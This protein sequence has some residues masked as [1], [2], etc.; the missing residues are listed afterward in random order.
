MQPDKRFLIGGSFTT[1]NGVSRNRVARI[2][3]DGSLDSSFNPGTGSN[4]TVLDVALQ[5][6]NKILI[7]GAFTSYNGTSRNRLARLNTDGSLDSTFNVGTGTDS[8]IN[9][10]A[11]QQN[12]KIL[13]GGFFANY[14]GA[15]ANRLA[16]INP[17]GSLDNT[18]VSGFTNNPIYNVREILVQTNGRVLIGGVFDS[19]SGTA[20]NSLLQLVPDVIKS[21]LFDFDGDGKADVSVFRPSNSVWYLLN[22]QTGFSAVQFGISTDKIAPADYDADGKTDVAVFRDGNWYLLRSSL[23]FTSVQFGSVGDIPAP[24][25]FN[26]DGRAELAVF[27]P[28]NGFWYVLNLVN[29]QFS[30]VQF[31]TAEDKPVAADYDGDGKS[32]YGVYRPSSGIWYLLQSTKGFGAIQFGIATD[33]PVVGDYDGD[34]RADQAVYRAESGIWYLLK[35]TQGFA[36]VQFGLSTDLPAAADY[37]GDGKTDVAVFRPNGGNWYQLKSAQGFGAVQFGSIGDKPAPNAFVP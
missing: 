8:A 18:F 15:S 9:T 33:K 13:I 7:A 25:D 6:D 17:D 35:T 14:N 23:G 37:D 3:A 5:P 24:A 12:G 32:D 22:S 20:H 28:S 30:S 11:L 2:N 36:S 19:Y 27:R 29:N 26:G 16:R 4:G 34:G 10:I 21:T 1:Y 31:G